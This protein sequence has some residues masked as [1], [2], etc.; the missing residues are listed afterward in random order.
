MKSRLDKIVDWEEMALAAHYE[1]HSMARACGVPLRRLT[2]HFRKAFGKTLR[3]WVKELASRRRE[4]AACLCERELET[5]EVESN[6]DQQPDLSSQLRR[7]YGAG[8][9]VY[10]L[11]VRG[12]TKT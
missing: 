1:P 8:P 4:E 2:R 9:R 7:V 6:C 10:R 12:S 3:R 5:V 11:L